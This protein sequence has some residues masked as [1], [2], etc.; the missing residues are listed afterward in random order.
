MRCPVKS[1]RAATFQRS[2]RRCCLASRI[3]F[4]GH[5]SYPSPPW[6]L[7]IKR[8][9]L[10]ARQPRRTD[11]D[12]IGCAAF[13]LKT[14]EGQSNNPIGALHSARKGSET[15]QTRESFREIPGKLPSASFGNLLS[16]QL[17]S[18]AVALFS[19]AAGADNRL[20]LG[21]PNTPSGVRSACRRPHSVSGVDQSPQSPPPAASARTARRS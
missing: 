6:S 17:T 4:Q 19:V 15:A 3:I 12:K 9:G 13:S 11:Q 7:G 21:R 20:G 10:F 2:G 5:G 1:A 8:Q 16:E 18:R 14:I